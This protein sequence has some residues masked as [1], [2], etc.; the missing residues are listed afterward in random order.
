MTRLSALCPLFLVA[1][2]LAGVCGCVRRAALYDEIAASR[3]VAY[4]RWAGGQQRDA[5]EIAGALSLPDAV[6]LALQYN[7]PLQAALHDREIARGQLLASYSEALPTVDATV[8]YTRLDELAGFDVGGTTVTTGELDNYSADVTVRQPLFRGGAVR[9]AIR[10]AKLYV[11]LTDEQ[12]RVRAQETI[13]A[14]GR[15]YFETLLARRLEEV[16]RQAVVSAEAH[17]ED[18]RAKFERG[19]ASRYDVLRAQVDLS[20]FRAQR[21]EQSHRVHLARTELLK[22]LGVSQDSDVRLSDELTYRPARPV[23]DRAVEIA[24]QNRPDLHAA[25]LG[26]RTQR[27]A[28]RMAYSRYWPEV[29]ATFTQAWT[30]PD[31]HTDDQ[32]WGRRWTGG[33]ELIWPIFDGLQREGDVIEQRARLRKRTLELADAEEQ[34]V[35]DVRQAVLSLADAEEFVASQR[36]NLDRAA[37]GLRLAQVG[38]REGVNTE[39]EVVDARAAVTK[40]RGLYY[41]AVYNHTVARLDLQRA[42]GILGPPPASRDVTSRP[43]SVPGKLEI[44][45]PEGDAAT[46]PAGGST[47]EDASPAEAGRRRSA[48]REGADSE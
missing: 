22:T 20:N 32:S 4:E 43:R 37:E 39:V 36:M 18:V 9:A 40:A 26:I 25:E 35:L 42:M 7:K 19:A 41:R 6:K 28:V 38:Y 48:A 46:R 13:Y 14:V 30:R 2:C 23:L 24:Y 45:Q 33:V 21:I 10:A 44:F 15:G 11:V 29:Y 5:V 31:P 16:N 8:S 34:T 47:G 3:R 17:L 12:L 27:E 1:V